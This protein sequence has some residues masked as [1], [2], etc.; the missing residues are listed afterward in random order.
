[1]TIPVKGLIGLFVLMFLGAL[2]AS[3]MGGGD[4]AMNDLSGA[5]TD[6]G[7]SLKTFQVKSI[8]DVFYSGGEFLWELGQFIG[9]CIFW[10]FAFFKGFEWIQ[11]I[12]ILVNMGILC[13][14]LFDFFRA[15]KPFGG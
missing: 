2:I 13:V 7:H 8:G 15:L 4:S 14:I 3:F 12:L 10:N 11:T 9:G 5:A 1:M 6:L